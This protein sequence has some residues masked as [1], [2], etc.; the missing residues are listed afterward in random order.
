VVRVGV[1]HTGGEDLV[2]LLAV[3]RDRVG[4]VDD[5]ED[6]GAAE[7]GDLHG[8]HAGEVMACSAMNLTGVVLGRS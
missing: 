8:T 6:L 2:E 5:V 7:T 4:E 1:V 3:P